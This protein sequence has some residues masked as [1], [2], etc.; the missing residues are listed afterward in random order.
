MGTPGPVGSVSRINTLEMVARPEPFD[1]SLG[2][3]GGQHA[4]RRTHKA[5]GGMHLKHLLM[6]YCAIMKLI[7]LDHPPCVTVVAVP[8]IN[9]LPFYL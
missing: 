4:V 5:F 2:D 1:F 6:M 7:S 9:F 8:C 3:E